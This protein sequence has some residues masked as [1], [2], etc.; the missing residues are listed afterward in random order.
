MKRKWLIPIVAPALLVAAIAQTRPDRKNAKAEPPAN[1]S[2]A[3]IARIIA[4]MLPG[5]TVKGSPATYPTLAMQMSR[6]QVPSLTVAVVDHGQIVWA[7]GFGVKSTD[8]KDPVTATTLFQAA[9]ISKPITATATLRLVDKGKLSLDENVNTYLKSWKVP[10]N[11]FTVKEKVTLRRILSHMAGLTMSSVPGFGVNDPLPTVQQ[12]LSG[13][14]PAKNPPLRVDTVP[15]TL[16]RYSGGG[17]A[18]EQ[19][20]LVDVVGKTFPVLMK[21]LVLKPIGMTNSTFEQPLPTALQSQAASAHMPDG[22]VMPPGRYRVYP[23]AAAAGL[24]TTPTDLLKWAMEVT[25][26]RAGRSTRVLSRAIATEMLT[27]Q[28]EVNGLGPQLNGKARGFHFEHGGGNPGFSSYVIYFPETGQGAALMTNGG[29]FNGF[30]LFRSIAEEF[31]WPDYRM[32]VLEPISLD[33]VD[34]DRYLG[35]FATAGGGTIELSRQGS[36]LFLRS[37]SNRTDEAALVGRDKL[38]ILW[39]GQAGTITFDANGSAKTV[40]LFG[41]VFERQQ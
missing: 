21:E 37:P 10:D 11:E 4:G 24:W 23:A 16:R 6:Y 30:E 18:V 22:S 34:L 9:S 2:K 12:T 19:I 28:N 36:R 32:Q 38:V 20:L 33:P 17:V 13:Q 14:P 26:A 5:A 15:G 41:D 7:E 31:D 35:K 39:S 27:P 25:A 1:N 3:R 8:S 29:R 40:S